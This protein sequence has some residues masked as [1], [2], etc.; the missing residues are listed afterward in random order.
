LTLNVYTGPRARFTLDGITVAL[1]RDVSMQEEYAHEPVKPLEAKGFEPVDYN[2]SMSAAEFMVIGKTLESLGLVARK[3]QSSQEHLRNVLS[4]E[5]MIAQLEDSVG[6]VIVATAYGV[7]VASKEFSVDRGLV[8][9]N[10]GFVV[11]R[12]KEG[13]LVTA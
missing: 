2:A 13:P 12:I 9:R 4:I 1:A 8:S 7:R 10:I 11:T 5:D 6:E 3:G